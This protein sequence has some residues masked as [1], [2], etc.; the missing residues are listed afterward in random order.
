[1]SPTQFHNSVHNAVAGYWSIAA[2]SQQPITCLG[3]NDWTFAAALLQAFAETNAEMRPTLL[4]VYDAP[5][6]APLD[7]ARHTAFPFA[8]AIVLSPLVQVGSLG[9]LSVSY[10][11]APSM[12]EAHPSEPAIR[13]L[14]DG[15]A[16]ARSLR[17]LEALASGRQDSFQHAL[18][19]GRIDV[20]VNQ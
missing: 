6:P 18:L 12:N 10:E 8:A 9:T 11:A 20:A 13:D 3:C 7:K 14:P 17:L 2:G 4:C 16:A 15:N 1:M 5:L 19:D